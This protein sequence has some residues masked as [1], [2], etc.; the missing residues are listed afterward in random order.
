MKAC[1][2]QHPG[3]DLVLY[4]EKGILTVKS[5]GSYIT[6]HSPSDPYSPYFSTYN[7]LQT[8]PSVYNGTAAVLDRHTD[9]KFAAIDSQ[10]TLDN[11]LLLFNIVNS[12]YHSKPMP[13]S[14]DLPPFSINGR[15]GPYYA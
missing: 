6:L 15:S 10:S 1:I 3:C 5:D 11:Q 13:Y 14:K 8:Q 7:V 9:R 2:S 4:C 12:L